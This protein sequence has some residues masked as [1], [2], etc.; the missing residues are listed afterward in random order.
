MRT[1]TLY[2]AVTSVVFLFL[3]FHSPV[4]AYDDRNEDL[5]GTWILTAT[6]A[7]DFINTELAAFNPGGTWT[8][9]STVFNAHSSQDPFLPPFLTID[10]S[11]GY[12]A[13][14]A[15]SGPDRFALTFK[16]HLFAG[17]TTPIDLYGPFFIGQY[18][19]EATIQA[20]AAVRHS[21]SGDTLQGQFTFQ[22]RN[23]RGEVTGTGSG[24]FSGV[25]LQIEPL[26]GP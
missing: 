20:V 8:T 21:D 10:T 3:A 18:V 16:R 4:K 7:P 24:P 12:G 19:G 6:L 11:D 13:W 25:R 2:L 1:R 5:V 9:T 17:A 14:R 22:A 26:E 15:Q 23:L